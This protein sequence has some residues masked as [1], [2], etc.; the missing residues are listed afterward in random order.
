MLFRSRSNDI[1]GGFVDIG[2]RQY[3]LRFAGRYAP[4]NLD[5]LVLEW[6][7]GSP[8]TLGDIADI[9]IRR[10]DSAGIATQNGNPALSVRIDKESSA[11]ALQTLNRVKAVVEELNETILVDEQV[12]MVQSFDASVFIYRAIN[13]VTSNLVLGVILSVGVLWWFLRRFRATMI[14][15]IAI[16]VSLLATFIVLR[17]TGRTLNVI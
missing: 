2:R 17:F 4:E 14:V 7:N 12:V 11:N 8:V 3:T 6:R 5:G 10:A 9:E 13:L 16:P 15:A 1:S